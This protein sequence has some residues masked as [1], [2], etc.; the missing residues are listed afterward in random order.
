MRDLAVLVV[1][2]AALAGCG[3]TQD[4]AAT[5]AARRLLDAAAAG[6]G[7]GACAALAAP[8]RDELE[9][10]SGKPCEEA[11]LEEELGGDG[12]ASVEVFDTMAQVVVGAETVFLSRYDGRWRVVAAGCTPVPDRPYDCSIGLP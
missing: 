2:C 8:T 9:Q 12:P 3:G 6:D 1:A 4:D 11:V 10:S 7:P 5:T